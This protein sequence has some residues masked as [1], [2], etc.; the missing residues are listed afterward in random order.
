MNQSSSNLKNNFQNRTAPDAD[1]LETVDMDTML[2]KIG[3]KRQ[4][5]LN[6]LSLGK[7][8]P[9]YI[10]VSERRK[11]WFVSDIKQWLE[12]RRVVPCPRPKTPPPLSGKRRPGRPTN[13]E[14]AARRQ[15]GWGK[16]Q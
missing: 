4:T 9:P 3:M 13:A 5:A 1:G 6:R 7:D 10:Q 2:R 12:S 15:F 14:I 11:M 8:M 16:N